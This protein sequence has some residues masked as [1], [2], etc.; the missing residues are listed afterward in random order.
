MNSIYAVNSPYPQITG[1]C[2]PCDI[3][4]IMDLYSGRTGE[5]TSITQYLYEHYVIDAIDEKIS[6][7]VIGLAKV[8]MLHHAVLGEAIVKLGGDPIM[9]GSTC[10]WSGSNLKYTKNPICFLQNSLQSE[11]NAV[12]NYRRAAA[13]TKNQSLSALLLRIAED[14]VLHIEILEN[15]LEELGCVEP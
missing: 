14:E 8:E 1:V 5:L 10:F 13:C 3:R 4:L 11:K 15:L 2:S 12:S 6:K 9:G 7:T